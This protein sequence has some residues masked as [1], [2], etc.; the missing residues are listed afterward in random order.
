MFLGGVHDLLDPVDVRGEA[1]HDDPLVRCAEHV[2]DDRGDLPLAGDE[3]RNLGVRGV[4]H[5]QVDA[6]RPQPGERPEVGQP[7]VQRKL[8]HLE[9]AGVQ[10]DPGGGADGHGQGIGDRVVHRDELALER[11]ERAALVLGDLDLDR[12]DPVLGELALDQPER[13]PRPDQRDVGTLPQ[14][15]RHGADVV[16]VRVREHEG[17]M[18]CRRPRM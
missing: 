2:V 9:V 14:Q 13:E 12:L 17:S 7:P 1:G 8:V 11:A 6:L 15:V 16:F 10:H 5:Q 4:R 18:S 3:T